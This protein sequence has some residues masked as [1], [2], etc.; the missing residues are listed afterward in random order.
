MTRQGYVT[1]SVA[2]WTTG[3]LGCASFTAWDCDP[4][5]NHVALR[6]RATLVMCAGPVTVNL[7]MSRGEW[8]KLA[9]VAAAKAASIECAQQWEAA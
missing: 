3:E 2:E 1:W 9:E 5:S 6:N 4:D 7:N 8:L